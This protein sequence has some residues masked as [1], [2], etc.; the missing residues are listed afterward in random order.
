MFEVGSSDFG[1]KRVEEGKEM[2]WSYGPFRYK[3]ASRAEQGEIE[4]GGLWEIVQHWSEHIKTGRGVMD[5]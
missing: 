4:G 3:P 1:Y 2:C 5:P